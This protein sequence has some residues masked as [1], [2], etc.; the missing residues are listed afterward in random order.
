MPNEFFRRIDLC[1]SPPLAEI[2]IVL[3]YFYILYRKTNSE[4][5][6]KIDSLLQK[7]TESDWFR[8]KIIKYKIF[9]R[10]NS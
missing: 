5:V 1:S 8:K 7:L 9:L 3:S 4:N 2:K 6:I 10:Q